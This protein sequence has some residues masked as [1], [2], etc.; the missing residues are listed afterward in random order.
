MFPT[1]GAETIGGHIVHTLHIVPSIQPSPVLY[2]ISP[3]WRS[4]PPTCLQAI[5][6]TPCLFG[7]TCY[8]PVGFRPFSPRS[9]PL[10][11]PNEV[12]HWVVLAGLVLCC[13]LGNKLHRF[14]VPCL[15][16]TDANRV[17]ILCLLLGVLGKWTSA[18]NIKQ[19]KQQADPQRR[20]AD[21]GK[22][23]RREIASVSYIFG[24]TWIFHDCKGVKWNF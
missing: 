1:G 8:I 19:G 3:C 21:M 6:T 12:L 13:F 17:V 14:W 15:G 11:N 24:N 5:P 23:T 20:S 16:R 7:R 4:H 10:I 18:W 2:L 22:R 9:K